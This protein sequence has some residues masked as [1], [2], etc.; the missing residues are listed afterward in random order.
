MRELAEPTD[1]KVITGH[2]VVEARPQGIDKGSALRSLGAHPPFR[3]RQPVFVGD[4][5]TD[6]DGFRAASGLGGFGVKV[7]RGAS[8]A[9]YR[10]E[11]VDGVHAWLRES[12]AALAQG[13]AR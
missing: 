8:I 3:D 12:L 1:L 13:T 11:A 9:R 10:I 5:A 4:D 2:A 6:E 7:G